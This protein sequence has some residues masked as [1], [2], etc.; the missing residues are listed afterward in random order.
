MNVS[1]R[2]KNRIVGIVLFVI[3]LLFWFIIIPKETMGE[4]EALFPEL[5][6]VLLGISSVILIFQRKTDLVDD[7]SNKKPDRE[8]IFRVVVTVVAFGIYLVLVKF[9]G[10]FISSFILLSAL[11]AYFGVKRLRT[12]LLIPFIIVV[13]IYLIIERFLEFPLPRGWIF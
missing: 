10:F 2:R 1:L 9:I 12:I 7:N 8:A 11:M 3:C 4:E 6:T 5:V 13:V